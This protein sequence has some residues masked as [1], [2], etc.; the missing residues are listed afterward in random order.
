MV[1]NVII[2]NYYLYV[3]ILS[4]RFYYYII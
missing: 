3:V 4:L 2:V 1:I